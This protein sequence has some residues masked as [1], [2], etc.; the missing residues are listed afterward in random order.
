MLSEDVTIKDV[1][2]LLRDRK[3]YAEC[4]LNSMDYGVRKHGNA[5]VRIGTDGRGKYCHTELYMT[6]PMRA[7]PWSN[8]CPIRLVTKPFPKE[9]AFVV[10][11]DWS[12][13]SST[14]AEVEELLANEIRDRRKM[15]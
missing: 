15:R 7:V 5:R 4:V 11:G 14:L 9:F 3:A 10:P 13:A 6:G 2:H 12:T 8:T 1:W